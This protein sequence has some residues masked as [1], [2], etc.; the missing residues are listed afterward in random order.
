[1][2]LEATSQMRVV[3][4]PDFCN[5]PEDL[6]RLF[7]ATAEH[8]FFSTL[9]WYDVLCRHTLGPN[10]RP[11]IYLDRLKSP[12]AGLLC[13]S[14]G[15]RTAHL[16]GLTNSYSCE[17]FALHGADGVSNEALRE[18]AQQIAEEHPRWQRITLSGFEGDDRGFAML[19]DG[20]RRAGM[21]VKPAFDSGTWYE[22]TSG[23]SFIDYLGQRPSQLR[24]TWRRRLASAERRHRLRWAFWSDVEDIDRG[25]ADYESIYRASWKVAEPFPT[26]MPAL[27]RFAALEGAVRL[28]I[29]YVDDVPAAAQFWIVW[30]G[31]ACI[32][33]LA[34]DQRFDHLSL[35]TLLT[36]R[37][38]ERVLEI[39]K[40]REINLG[41][42][43][44]PYK[45]LW[46]PRR[47]ERWGVIAANSR[48]LAGLK[49]AARHTAARMLRPWRPG[50]PVPPV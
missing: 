17:H 21:F 12:R 2:A 32:Y 42:G 27:I 39:D 11:R 13:R 45:K 25:I 3:E 19:A 36:M 5:L 50:E 18:I 6:L 35:G 16:S 1:M 47:R 33:K 49:L 8:S 20:L 38:T 37:M 14:N 9:G 15:S 28:G 7:S 4:N 31:K 48:S 24:N 34:H 26:F 40:P 41:R 46:L 44:D 22:E 30:R 29:I 23:M 10:E 43:D